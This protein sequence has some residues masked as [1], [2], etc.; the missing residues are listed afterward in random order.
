MNVRMF[1]SLLSFIL[2]SRFTASFHLRIQPI[3]DGR[4]FMNFFMD[5]RNE[6]AQMTMMMSVTIF[7][8]AA[9]SLM[10]NTSVSGTSEKTSLRTKALSIGC[11]A[12]APSK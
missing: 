12:G 11:V 10:V 1:L 4:R 8:A 6:M 3:S 9:L 2:N 5:K 7:S